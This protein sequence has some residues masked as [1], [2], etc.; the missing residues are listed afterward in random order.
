MYKFSS[1]VSSVIQSLSNTYAPACTS[2][3]E[4]IAQFGVQTERYTHCQHMSSQCVCVYDMQHRSWS[5]CSQNLASDVMNVDCSIKYV[6]VSH[7]TDHY[8]VVVVI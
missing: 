6:Y 7:P 8:D 1:I 2:V 3:Q 4:Y 5:V